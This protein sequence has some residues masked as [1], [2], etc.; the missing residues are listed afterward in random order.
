[1]S[2]VTPPPL[3]EAKVNDQKL[4]EPTPSVAWTRAL[5]TRNTNGQGRPEG[6]RPSV[7]FSLR[8]RDFGWRPVG[9]QSMA[10]GG[11][12]TAVARQPTAV[13]DDGSG[14]TDGGWE[15]AVSILFCQCDGGFFSPSVLLPPH[16]RPCT[17]AVSELDRAPVNTPVGLTWPKLRSPP[18]PCWPVPVHLMM[19]HC[20]TQRCH[21]VH[22][23]R[24]G[25]SS[26]A[27]HTSSHTGCLHAVGAWGYSQASFNAQGRLPGREHAGTIW[28]MG[29]LSQGGVQWRVC[30]MKSH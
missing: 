20:T 13:G 7:D 29:R 11:Y 25:I 28:K 23:H 16:E 9:G 19:C 27:T 8:D 30:F 26:C 3:S 18:V 10:V 17:Q 22:Q 12:Q 1:M 14:V 4:T 2:Y 6:S 24:S 5:L 15:I 21:R